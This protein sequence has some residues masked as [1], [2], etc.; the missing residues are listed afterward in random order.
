M[1]SNDN[2][3]DM[4]KVFESTDAL[5]NYLW[6]GLPRNQLLANKVLLRRMHSMINEGGVWIYPDR[7]LVFEKRGNGFVLKECQE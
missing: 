5:C 2:N 6:S 7:G 3:K 1:S 4:K